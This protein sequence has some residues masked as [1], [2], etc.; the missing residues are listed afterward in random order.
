MRLLARKVPVTLALAALALGAMGCGGS[1]NPSGALACPAL[2]P[3]VSALEAKYS[4]DGGVNAQVRAYVQAAKDMTWVSTRIEHLAANA[5]RRIGADLGLSD[6]AMQ[7]RSGPGGAAVGACEPV[8]DVLDAVLRQ[9]IR[10]WATIGPAQCQ[11]NANAH[12]RCNGA[13]NVQSNP[14]CMASCRAHANVH[15]SCQPA[16]V[17]VRASHGAEQAAALLATLNAN[18]PALIEA[19]YTLGQRISADALAIAKLGPSLRK[20]TDGASSDARDCIAA[21]AEAAAQAALRIRV[22]TRVANNFNARVVG[23]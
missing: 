22:S 18:L 14:T 10:V 5:C 17:S 13:C 12:A 4:K 1:K 21:S 11:P 8:S 7:P 15:A 16:S 9:G 20:S 2:Q 19:Q 23:R 3:E 6:E